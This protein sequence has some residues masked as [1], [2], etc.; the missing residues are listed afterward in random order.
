MDTEVVSTCSV[1]YCGIVLALG[2]K[3][4]SCHMTVINVQHFKL[5]LGLSYR[6]RF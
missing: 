2:V 6:L 1:A 5:K 4:V 3:Y